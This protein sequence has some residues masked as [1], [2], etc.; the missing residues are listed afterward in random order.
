[1]KKT[2][3]FLLAISLMLLSACS[4]PQQPR[5]SLDIATAQTTES[6]VEAPAADSSEPVGMET[7]KDPYW[8]VDSLEAFNELMSSADGYAYY[9]VFEKM[10]EDLKV[11]RVGISAN[12]DHYNIT[13]LNSEN[14]RVQLFVFTIPEGFKDDYDSWDTL[15]VDGVTYYYSQELESP[16]GEKYSDEQMVA[17][18]QWEQDGKAILVHPKE[19]ITED[20]IRKYNK[21]IKVEFNEGKQQ[22]GLDTEQV[23][24]KDIDKITALVRSNPEIHYHT[25]VYNDEYGD[26]LLR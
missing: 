2:I 25:G 8:E 6:S 21:L 23:L 17:Y 19:P 15:S 10:P 18:F 1:M 24:I 5:P 11:V 12:M 26:D 3:L 7:Y 16:E 4:K 14:E 9:Y 13:F 20:V 22:V